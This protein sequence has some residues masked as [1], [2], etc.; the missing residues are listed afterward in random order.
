MIRIIFILLVYLSSILLYSFEE[1]ELNRALKEWEQTN[2][3]QTIVLITSPSSGIIEYAY[4]KENAFSKKLP[5]GSILKT[6]SSFVFLANPEKFNTS[7]EKYFIC[8]GKF[9][10]PYSNFFTIEDTNNY[11]I[12]KNEKSNK[13]YYNCSL[14]SGH[15]EIK[16]SNALALSCNSYYLHFASQNPKFFYDSLLKDWKLNEGTGASFESFSKPKITRQKT[17]SS[18]ASSLMSIGNGG[19][20]KV[21]ALKI[22]QIYGAIFAN[23]QIL[24]PIQKGEMPETINSFP[25]SKDSREKIQEALRLVITKGTLKNLSLKNT[26]IQVLGGKTGTPTKTGN[27]TLTH[28]WNIIYFRKGDNLYLLVVFTENGSGKRE[29]LEL[30]TIIL[31]LL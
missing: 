3:N 12:I 15:G 8:N 25:Y 14:A 31:N 5:A 26:S 23:S 28:G 19:E 20:I 27:K 4:T 17:I 24:K 29:A 13:F 11:N 22:A 30:S 1:S 7:W 6:L 2:H 16:M 18:F 10:E 9:E 21:T